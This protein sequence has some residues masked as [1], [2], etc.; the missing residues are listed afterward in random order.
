[1][2]SPILARARLIYTNGKDHPVA[3]EPVGANVFLPYQGKIFLSTGTS[4]ET[5]RTIMLVR[6]DNV[7]PFF[8][9]FVLFS[10]GNINKPTS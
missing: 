4:G 10:I 6:Q 1:M 7:L 5:K 2:G 9:D 8:F 3:F